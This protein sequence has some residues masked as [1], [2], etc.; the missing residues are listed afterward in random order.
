MVVRE[1]FAELPARRKFLR[2][3][4]G[5]GGQIAALA[6]QLALAFPEIA[7]SLTIDGRP[8]LETDG[9]D[10]LVAVVAAVYGPAV[11]RGMVMIVAESPPRED[12]VVA[13]CLGGGDTSLPTRS[14]ITLY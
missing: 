12:V 8:L 6:S 10:D 2:G 11:A 7:F 13:G 14:G 3:R 4:S 1:L 9:S 5:E